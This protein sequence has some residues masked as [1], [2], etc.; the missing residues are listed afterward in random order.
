MHINSS[1]SLLGLPYIEMASIFR[2]PAHYWKLVCQ[3]FRWTDRKQDVSKVNNEI[4]DNGIID[5]E[6]SN[7]ILQRLNW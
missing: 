7:Q 3:N 2:Q 6:Q 5:K 1:H 4:L